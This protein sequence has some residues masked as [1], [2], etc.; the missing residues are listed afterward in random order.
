MSVLAGF[1]AEQVREFVREYEEQPYGAKGP[2]LERQG[3]T[4]HQVRRWREVV[5]EGD[6]DRSLFPR[7]GV[8]MTSQG[9][10]TALE[11]QRERER[12]QH[13]AEIARLAERVRELEASNEALGKA[14]GLLHKLSAQEPDENPAP[15]A[16]SDSS[17][18]SES[19]SGS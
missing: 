17:S 9:K 2:W 7:K 15:S 6:L 3:L 16:R 4:R 10:R 14:I 8:R 13:E 12:A 5:F 11:K 19:S 18:Q 1:T